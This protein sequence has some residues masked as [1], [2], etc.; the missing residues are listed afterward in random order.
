MNDTNLTIQFFWQKGGNKNRFN[1]LLLEYGEHFYEDVSV[2]CLPLPS[3]TRTIQQCD[4]LK[5]Q[6][7]LKV[8]S[9]SLIFEPNDITKPI[10]R[11]CFK[12]FTEIP[13]S[14]S[15]PALDLKHC[16]FETSGFISYA[17]SSIIEMK[18]NNKI[19]PYK[20]VDEVVDNGRV[21]FS[22]LHSDAMS[23]ISKVDAVIQIYNIQQT[24][25]VNSASKIKLPYNTTAITSSFDTSLLVDFHE[26]LLL[27]APIPMK[28]VSPMVLNPGSIMITDRRIYYIPANINNVDETVQTIE[29]SKIQ[30]VYCR[31]YLLRPVGLELLM[32]DGVSWLFCFE[33]TSVREHVY[34]LINEHPRLNKKSKMS[35]AD[36]TAKWQKKEITNFEYLMYLN[37]EADRSVND[38][39]QYPV[40]P[41]VIQDYT[42]K[43]LDLKSRATYR[44]LSL[45]VGALNPSRLAH[46]RDRFRSMPECDES[47]GIPPPFMY[48]THY[49]TPGY[50]LYYLVRVAPE[51]MLC[52]QAGKFDSADRMFS[53][54]ADSW[55]SC[56]VN[57]ADLKELVPEF[58]YG[59][60]DF[61][62]NK[63]DLDMGYRQT[64]ERLGD[65]ELPPWAKSPKDF[66]KKNNKAIESSY[67]S[68]H[69]NDWIDLIFG[70]KQRGQA[71]VDADNV[72]YHLTYEGSVDL[73]SIKSARER[74]ALEIQIQ[75][76]GQTP[77][78]LFTS[79]HPK[80]SD[81]PSKADKDKA[82]N[83]E[84][85]Y[86]ASAAAPVPLTLSASDRKSAPS[87]ESTCGEVSTVLPSMEGA[88]GGEMS[89]ES[90]AR[91][92]ENFTESVR[93][94][95]NDLTPKPAHVP[96][97]SEQARTK[98]TS[99]GLSSD[100]SNSGSNVK[101]SS[102]TPTP[103]GNTG[104]PTSSGLFNSA[105]SNIY[106]F[107]GSA[108]KKPA[109]TPVSNVR[110]NGGNN[111][112]NNHNGD[113]N[114]AASNTGAKSFTPLLSPG[115]APS[116]A[117]NTPMMP[118]S[119]TPTMTMP[120]V[121]PP[122]ENNSP[123]PVITHNR[124][125]STSVD[126]GRQ[127]M[128]STTSNLSTHSN[129]STGPGTGGRR[130]KRAGEIFLDSGRITQSN[131]HSTLHT[132][133]VGAG[134]GLQ[135]IIN[136]EEFDDGM[137]I[138]VMQLIENET[139]NS[140]GVLPND[141]FSSRGVIP[142][143]RLI[144][145]DSAIRTIHSQDV[146]GIS[147]RGD[148]DRKTVCTCSQD[149][150]VKVVHLELDTTLN[151]VKYTVKRTF[152]TSLDVSPNTS[153]MGK[154]KV[155]SS[156]CRCVLLA[157]NGK[158]VLGG[159]TDSRLY[160]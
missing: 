110:S 36:Y 129:S 143:I 119:P 64:G 85:S 158:C 63:S 71:A 76:F 142:G 77:K 89:A 145:L 147:V 30:R 42:S 17:C 106:N 19:A 122:R 140:E 2:Y 67:V 144:P 151:T 150:Y 62:L 153:G 124:S 18:V 107:F 141:N 155:G 136:F 24:Q 15:L 125:D 92:E 25:G 45:P 160:R 21:L 88:A 72:F 93:R 56:Y 159:S 104:A 115:T 96:G 99:A 126:Q 128:H 157:A 74:H 113:S 114:A 44:D 7:R 5:V 102:A 47:M 97:T 90:S 46:F 118:T 29:I 133:S 130:S 148:I 33:E 87:K 146:C 52:L 73:E 16:M 48:G 28:K 10:V 154:A 95:V 139:D 79:P 149:G 111:K 103:I 137:D 84:C 3:S 41:H 57:P 86:T 66:I 108:T 49:S 22:L 58:F 40:F 53:S 123:S 121:P 120:P 31:R 55:D 14:Y 68:E 134:F 116:T 27:E 38:I 94:E 37:Y 20:Q 39:T 109:K 13:K 6:G 9:R 11:Y 1:L 8:C 34:A 43:S 78:Q 105:V 101:D 4:S 91:I 131:S 127:R 12:N 132:L 61:L 26:T 59:S 82:G 51:H 98:Q 83:A 80:R 135:D 35:L 70:Y 152:S 112:H 75:E 65:V 69:L 60:G 156:M 50:V 138:P 54:I 32:R 100:N 117:H 81:K 23:L